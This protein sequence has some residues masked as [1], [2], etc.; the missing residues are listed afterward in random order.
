VT[1]ISLEV[2]IHLQNIFFSVD[3]TGNWLTDVTKRTVGR[4]DNRFTI[5]GKNTRVQVPRRVEVKHMV[6]LQQHFETSLSKFNSSTR[7]VN[8][9]LREEI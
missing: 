7:V 1:Q 6:N 5:S 4:K 8:V 3:D 9:V 2:L